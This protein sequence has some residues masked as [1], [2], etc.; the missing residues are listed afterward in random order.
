M[1]NEAKSVKKKKDKV[2][3][4]IINF[5]F[6]KIKNNKRLEKDLYG[7]ALMYFVLLKMG[8]II[9]SDLESELNRLPLLEENILGIEWKY[10]TVINSIKQHHDS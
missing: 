4:K 2:D 5:D 1:D 9:W 6:E 10:N 8:L 3:P 7:W